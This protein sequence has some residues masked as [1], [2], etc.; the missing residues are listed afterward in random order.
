MS[1][2]ASPP[3]LIRFLFRAT[4]ARGSTSYVE[5]AHSSA[6]L[7]H[8]QLRSQGYSALQLLEDGFERALAS[9]GLKPPGWLAN[10]PVSRGATKDQVMA[11]KS[12]WQTGKTSGSHP[13]VAAVLLMWAWRRAVGPTPLSGSS[14]GIYLLNGFLAH[15][16]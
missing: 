10:G 1:E 16:L 8:E 3:P 7:A 2:T 14:I 6:V 15:T 13:V 5:V 11:P 9:A 4:D 12:K